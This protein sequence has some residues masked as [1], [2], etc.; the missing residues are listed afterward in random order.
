MTPLLLLHVLAVAVIS[1]F[2]CHHQHHWF[3]VMMFIGWGELKQ[4]ISMEIERTRQLMGDQ[5]RSG[6]NMSGKI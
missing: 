6:G 3:I 5:R 4:Y 1:E 2:A